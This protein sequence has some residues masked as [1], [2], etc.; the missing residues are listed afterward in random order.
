MGT[1]RVLCPKPLAMPIHRLMEAWVDIENQRTPYEVTAMEPED[2]Y[3]VKN[4]HFLRAFETVHT[5][6]SLGY[7]LI[8]KRSK[9]KEEYVGLPQEKLVE[10]KKAGTDITDQFEIPLICYTGDTAWGK[11]FERDDV[12]NAKVLITECTFME[13]GHRRRA[14]I[15]KHLHLDHILDLLERSTAEAV[16]LTHLSRRTPMGMVRKTLEKHIPEADRHRVFVLMD[17]R[18]NRDRY[19][20]QLAEAESIA[21]D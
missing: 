9:L 2:E 14:N 8:E 6:A 1:G 17:N 5:V 11:H 19:E 10:L 4:N 13:S 3:V 20:Q 21:G 16:V 12:I 7:S 18:S 15:G